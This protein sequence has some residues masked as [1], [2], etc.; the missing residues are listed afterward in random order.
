MRWNTG[1]QWSMRLLLAESTP[2]EDESVATNASAKNGWRLTMLTERRLCRSGA[3]KHRKLL[4]L[5]RL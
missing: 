3:C 1:L 2:T 5:L 4:L